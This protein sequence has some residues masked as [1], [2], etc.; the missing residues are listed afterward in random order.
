MKRTTY[1][2]AGI[3][4]A[5][6]CA[7]AFTGCPHEAGDPEIDSRLEGPWTNSGTSYLEKKFTIKSNGAFEAYLNPTALGAYA[8]AY[9]AALGSGGDAAAAATSAAQGVTTLAENYSIDIDWHVTGKLIRLEGD[10]Y[11]MDSLKADASDK[12]ITDP[13]ANPPGTSDAATALAAIIQNVRIT[14]TDNSTFIFV[15]AETDNPA[16]SINMFFGGTYYKAD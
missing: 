16:D 6:T 12:L 15:N 4:L 8:Q 10:V 13:T 14:L 9:A 3:V 7:L 2:A 5:L 11:K 1:A